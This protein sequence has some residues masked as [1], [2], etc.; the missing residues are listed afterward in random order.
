M[1]GLG[2]GD[3][4][5]DPWG[6]S[7]GQGFRVEE[8]GEARGGEPEAQGLGRWRRRSPERGAG[9]RMRRDCGTRMGTLDPGRGRG[10]TLGAVVPEPEGRAL[11]K[12]TG[13]GQRSGSGMEEERVQKNEGRW[14]EGWVERPRGKEKGL[15]QRLTGEGN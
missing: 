4:D 14:V 10:Q 3:R 7:W 15:H 9:G 1:R 12:E 13:R 6:E 2:R 5:Q 8:K 11:G